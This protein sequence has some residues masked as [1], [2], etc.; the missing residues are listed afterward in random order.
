MAF[1][2]LLEDLVKVKLD[3]YVP[4][5]PIPKGSMKHIGKGRMVDQQG[6]RLTNWQSNIATVARKALNGHSVTCNYIQVLFILPPH[7]YYVM[8][9][10]KY[11]GDKMLR[12]VMDAL[13]GVT[14]LDDSH[15]SAYRVDI[16]P[17][18]GGRFTQT[19]AYILTGE[20]MRPLRHG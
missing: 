1:P 9:T 3:I 16:L 18:E 13:T 4:G 11:D 14:W 12:A 6:T 20:I 8:G 10:D 5:V 2:A 7:L 17:C 19:G 15:P